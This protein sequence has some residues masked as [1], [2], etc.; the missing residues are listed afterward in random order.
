MNPPALV[1]IPGYQ[2]RQQR[3]PLYVA[4]IEILFPPPPGEKVKH[5]KLRYNLARRWRRQCEEATGLLLIELEQETGFPAPVV[6]LDK[7]P[8]DEPQAYYIT[9][10][11]LEVDKALPIA[12]LLGRTMQRWPILINWE[13]GIQGDTHRSRRNS[14]WPGPLT[15]REKARRRRLERI[16][17]HETKGLDCDW[18]NVGKPAPRRSW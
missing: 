17:S 8:Y 16:R 10:N 15:D 4:S 1:Q 11:F 3:P 14:P 5:S 9:A 18:R 6:M 12:L 13:I 2:P 7:A